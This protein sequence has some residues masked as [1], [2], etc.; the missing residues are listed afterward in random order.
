MMSVL[1][2]IIFLIGTF[3]LIKFGMKIILFI[4]QFGLKVILFGTLMYF[5]YYI[6][7]SDICC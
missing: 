6:F 7:F 3:Y 2:L 4:L 5:V 1:L